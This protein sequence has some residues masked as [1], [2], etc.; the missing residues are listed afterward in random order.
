MP[1]FGRKEYA[2][3][4]AAPRFAPPI[5]Y[6]N[7]AALGSGSPMPRVMLLLMP[8]KVVSG[9]ELMDAGSDILISAFQSI[10]SRFG[11]MLSTLAAVAIL[12][13][14]YASCCSAGAGLS[15]LVLS[16]VAN[17]YWGLVAQVFAVSVRLLTKKW[18]PYVPIRA[19]CIMP[20]ISFVDSKCPNRQSVNWHRWLLQPSPV[21]PKFITSI[22]A[23]PTCPPLS[24]DLD[25]LSQ[26]KS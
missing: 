1:V 10:V 7:I 9:S 4:A 6:Y 25:V 21:A 26:K 13:V 8:I 14:A 12:A 19:I 20:E 5:T 15:S 22:S 23:S 24:T 2:K 17:Q 16:L 3:P 18:L 11:M